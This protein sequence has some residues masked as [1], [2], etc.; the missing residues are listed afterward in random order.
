MAPMAMRCSRQSSL[1]AAC[2]LESAVCMRAVLPSCGG[3]AAV[4]HAVSGGG[5]RAAGWLRGGAHI[6]CGI[7]IHPLLHEAG[8]GGEVALLRRIKKSLLRL[9]A[10]P[11]ALSAS[12]EQGRRLR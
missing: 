1:P 9:R 8:E 12:Q 6:V 7:H 5:E 4:P 11:S 3:V 2:M 10:Q